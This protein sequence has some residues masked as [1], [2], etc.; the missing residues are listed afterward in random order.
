[1][2]SHACTGSPVC[3]CVSVCSSDVFVWRGLCSF[4]PRRQRTVG[5]GQGAL[6]LAEMFP[7]VM[8][9]TCG[10]VTGRREGG[11][12]Q[13]ALEGEETGKTMSDMTGAEQSPAHCREPPPATAASATHSPPARA[14]WQHA[15]SL[16][17]SRTRRSALFTLREERKLGKWLELAQSCVFFLL[18]KYKFPIK[19]DAF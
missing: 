4:K 11:R 18:F 1:M 3:V 9:A 13:E 17:G 6:V 8:L 12:R 15:T 5:G 7:S 19:S 2:L 10:W 14:V 16:I